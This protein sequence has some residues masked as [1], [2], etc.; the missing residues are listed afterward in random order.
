M[1]PA[2]IP[3]IRALNDF[4]S[5]VRDISASQSVQATEFRNARRILLQ[6]VKEAQELKALTSIRAGYYLKLSSS[7][8]SDFIKL[9]FMNQRNLHVCERIVE[10]QNVGAWRSD[11]PK[12]LKEVYSHR[13]ELPEI[14]APLT[15]AD[16]GDSLAYLPPSIKP[17]EFFACSTIP[18]LF[19]YCWTVEL[20]FAFI[21]FIG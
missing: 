13:R 1:L 20:Q 6:K 10:L 8:A 21:Q 16:F 7:N 3:S 9:P 17:R 2:S 19:G 15:N 5:Q 12:C 11:I 18:S 4:H 14:L